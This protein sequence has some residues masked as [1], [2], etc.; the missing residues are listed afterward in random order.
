MGASFAKLLNRLFFGGKDARI[1]MLGLDA[2]GKTTVLYNLKL[3]EVV[4]TIP[5]IGFNVESLQYRN[6]KF[7]VWDIGGQS[8]IR[9]LWHHYYTGTDALIYVVDSNDHERMEEASEELR[10]V[11]SDSEMHNIPV[12]ILANKQ[13][14]PYAL[15]VSAVA[16][17]LQL[18]SLPNKWFVAKTCATSGE[19]LYE[20]LD[21]LTNTLNRK[22]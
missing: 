11:L 20:G 3:G 5:T 13:D 1:L 7:V 22:K 2:A 14:L 12:L 6:I 8:K 15:S 21:W 17:K 16:Q 19:G 10:S 18:S 4:V 9:P